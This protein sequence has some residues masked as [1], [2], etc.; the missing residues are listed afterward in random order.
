MY[1]LSALQ[2]FSKMTISEIKKIAFEIG[3]KGTGGL[4]TNDPSPKYQL[5]SL[6]GNF[7]GLNLVCHMYV[8]FK[9]FAP[10]QDIGFDL[11]KEYALATNLHDKPELI[12]WN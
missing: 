3:L 1:C 8:G 2:R 5:I 12:T 4:D 11:S 7:S 10:E 6:P 9:A